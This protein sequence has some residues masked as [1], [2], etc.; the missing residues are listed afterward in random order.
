[1]QVQGKVNS[2]T[3]DQCHKTGLVFQDLLAACEVV[4][5]IGV[6]VQATGSVKTL[7]ID[8]SDGV[9]VTH[10]LADAKS[11]KAW[12]LHDKGSGFYCHSSCM[13]AATC[14]DSLTA[15]S[16]DPAA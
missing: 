3:L 9:Q 16:A 15:G 5:C 7:A 2:I 12:N 8:K 6:Q 4:N 1:M 13:P 11:A 14:A 10:R